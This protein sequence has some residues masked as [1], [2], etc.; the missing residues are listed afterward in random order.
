MDDPN[1]NIYSIL[2]PLDHYLTDF[3]DPEWNEWEQMYEVAQRLLTN[4]QTD[5]VRTVMKYLYEKYLYGDEVLYSFNKHR[6]LEFVA[7]AAS[8]DPYFVTHLASVDM[9]KLTNAWISNGSIHKY[10]YL[11]GKLSEVGYETDWNQ[12]YN[13]VNQQILELEVCGDNASGEFYCILHGFLMIMTASQNYLERQT[14][15][16]L[17]NEHWHFFRHL[18]SIMVRRIIGMRFPNFAGVANNAKNSTDCI[19]YLK[20]IYG[21]LVE[22]FDE[23]CQL[24]T[25]QKSLEKALVTISGVISANEQS[26][27]LDELCEILFPEEIREMLNTHRLP[28]YDQLRVENQA[29]REQQQGLRRQIQEQMRQAEE[30]ITQLTE[31]LKAGVEAAIPVEYIE[32]ELMRLPAGTAW[33]VFKTLNELLGANEIWRRYDISIRNKLI[34]RFEDESKPSAIGQMIG[35]QNNFGDING[36]EALLQNKEITKLL[37]L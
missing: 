16:K 19:P 15:F 2:L 33:D 20:L 37:N 23:L 24:G 8:I 34:K 14:R 6:A 1:F 9:M 36:A 17:F 21:A 12:M 13:K 4:R 35:T 25:K 27:E 5:E 3:Y 28:T 11:L 32:Q 7:Y 29:L 31:A 26:D 22:R 18:Y 10:R 30:K